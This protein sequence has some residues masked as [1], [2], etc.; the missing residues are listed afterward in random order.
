GAYSTR[1]EYSSAWRR[2]MSRLALLILALLAVGGCAAPAAVP[3]AGAGGS[4]AAGGAPPPSGGGGQTAPAAAA[5]PPTAVPPRVALRFGMNAPTANLAPA[6]VAKEEG[7]F[8][9]HGLD[10]ELV[11]IPGADLIVSSL[12]SGEVPISGLAAPA[13]VN[14]VLGGADLVFVGSYT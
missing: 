9:R 14:A 11:N 8:A 4:A 12:V 1:E 7:F 6:W 2:P 3:P 10:V 5:L 13:L